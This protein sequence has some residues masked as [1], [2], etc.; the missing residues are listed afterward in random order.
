M[1]TADLYPRISIGASVSQAGGEGISASQGFTY[2]VG[3]LLS[4]SFPNMATARARIKQAEG[5]NEAALAT[6]D[7]AVL[8]ALK[9]VEQALGAYRAATDRRSELVVAESRAEQA[10]RLADARYRSG[11]IAYLD[12]LVAQSDL[13]RIRLTRSQADGDVASSQVGVFRALGA[14]WLEGQPKTSAA[15]GHSDAGS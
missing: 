11:S 1:A 7:G 14:G 4:F 6:F 12:V 8:T 2:G 13:L 3:P 15:R 9:E 5:R 10:F